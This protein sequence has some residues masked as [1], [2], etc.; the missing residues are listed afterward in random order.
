MHDHL[1]I[2][3]LGLLAGLVA[4]V[5]AAIATRVRVL[6]DVIDVSII[7]TVAGL[8]GLAFTTYGALRRYDPD[9]VARLTLAGTVGGGCLGMFILLFA[10]ATKVV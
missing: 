10:L 6:P 7:L 8:G 9:R 3:T 2:W 5:V 4:T 1:L